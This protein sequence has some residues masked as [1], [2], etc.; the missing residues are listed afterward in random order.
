MKST[1]QWGGTEMGMFVAPCLEERERT[2]SSGNPFFFATAG[3]VGRGNHI[4]SYVSKTFE[5][6][7][8]SAV[9]P[10]FL[11]ILSTAAVQF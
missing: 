7:L 6:S 5:T 10:M 11:G 3:F 9:M 2:Y 1:A 4:I 8:P